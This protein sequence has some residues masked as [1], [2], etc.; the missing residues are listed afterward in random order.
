MGIATSRWIADT[1]PGTNGQERILD[2]G[3][4]IVR[5]R[6]AARKQVTGWPSDTWLR[7]LA[8]ALTLVT[9]VSVTSL[10]LS[11][12]YL[13]ATLLAV[14]NTCLARFLWR[15]SAGKR[16]WLVHQGAKVDESTDPNEAE[17]LE[18]GAAVAAFA[19]I[20]FTAALPWLR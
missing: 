3:P 10:V 18:V 9:A 7:G 16:A 15:R 19:T 5:K 17:Q 8:A 1:P 4:Q 2:D 20:I 12:E 14:F 11:N 13:F 6:V